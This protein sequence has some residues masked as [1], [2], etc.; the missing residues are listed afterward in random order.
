MFWD[1]F[2]AEST[3][4][5]RKIPSRVPEGQTESSSRN[6]SVPSRNWE[7]WRRPEKPRP[8]QLQARDIEILYQVFRH[9]FLQVRHVHALL[10]GSAAN[11]AVRLRLLWQHRYLERPNAIRPTRVLTEELVY[12]LGRRGAQLVERHHPEFR[13][14]HL[15]WSATPSKQSG[16]A[17]IDHQLGIATFMTV[18]RLACETIGAQLNWNGH[19]TDRFRIQVPGESRT[20]YPD[21]HFA[22]EVPNLGTAHHFLELDRGNVSLQRMEERYRRYFSFWQ[23]SAGES[24][25]HFRVITICEDRDHLE[26]LRRVARRAVTDSVASVWRALLFAPIAA[27]RLDEP[28][29]IL[30]EVFWYADGEQ[31]VSLLPDALS[32]SR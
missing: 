23:A 15:D 10:G 28:T 27:V 5:N 3:V 20:V 14:G 31:P 18:L 22:L 32:P 26:A 9:R 12:A 24:F 8:F 2:G 11:L 25:P 4:T 29:H 21:A 6:Q 16:L 13:I 30:K 19:Y 17:Y 7:L 1:F